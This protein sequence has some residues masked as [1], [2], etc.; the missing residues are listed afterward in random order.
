MENEIWKDIVDFENRYEISNC[1]RVRKKLNG[2]FINGHMFQNYQKLVL[3]KGTIKSR[4]SFYIHQLVAKHFIDNPNNYKIVKYIDN[5]KINNIVT[6]LKWISYPYKSKIKYK[7]NFAI[8]EENEIW[9]DMK[10]YEERYQS[11]N[12]GRIKN[13]I[14]NMIITPFIKKCFYFIHIS[15]GTRSSSKYLPVHRLIATDFVENSHNKKIVEHKD[16]NKF[17]NKANNLRWSDY[18]YISKFKNRKKIPKKS[19]KQDIK[20]NMI[21]N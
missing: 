19:N 18:P 2:E 1:G 5:N 11:S 20:K 9:K 14:T 12:L 10:N 8:D 13:K 3:S 17:N 4:K 15:N 21:I 7:N 6:N 16:R